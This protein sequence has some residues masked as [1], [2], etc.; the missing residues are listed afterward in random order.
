VPVVVDQVEIVPES[1]RGSSE[2]QTR[3]EAGSASGS[4]VEDLAI[5]LERVRE[6]DLRRS[7]F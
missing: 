5:A 7:P 4:P 1:V 6:R 3:P 2:P